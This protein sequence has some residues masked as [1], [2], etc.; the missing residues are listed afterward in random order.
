MAES[1]A[2][3]EQGTVTGQAYEDMVF[4]LTLHGW[5]K[6]VDGKAKDAPADLWKQE[7]AD[8]ELYLPLRIQHASFEWFD[9]H[10]R[11]SEAHKILHPTSHVWVEEEAAKKASHDLG[12]LI[13]R[14]ILETATAKAVQENKT[15]PAV[16]T[17][18]LRTYIQ[19]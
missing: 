2:T 8:R 16:V 17:E 4:L 14:I 10:E 19:T 1:E 13:P 3:T 5:T 6:V 7:E 9:I 12:S 18:L 11:I 15:L